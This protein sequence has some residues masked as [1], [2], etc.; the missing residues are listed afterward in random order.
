MIEQLKRI[1]AVEPR[2]DGSAEVFVRREDDTV[3]RRTLPFR[4]FLL[5]AFEAFPCDF[6]GIHV[7]SLAGRGDFRFKAE[8]DDSDRYDEAVALLKKTTGFSGGQVN[9]PFRLFSDMTQQ[10]LIASDLRLFTG[11]AFPELRRMQFDIE[12]LCS[13][14]YDFPNAER[15]EDSV[16]IISLS[17]STGW[18]K[19][20]S[21]AE[22]GRASCRERVLW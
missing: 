20:L 3:E 22:I 6:P 10:F 12:T 17:D 11:M 19:V 14:G 1:C 4:P 21:L 18:E 13:P 8:F 7:T 2:R 16:I 15:A 9:A 5:T